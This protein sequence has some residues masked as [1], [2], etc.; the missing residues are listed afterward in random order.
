MSRGKL[1]VVASLVLSLIIFPVLGAHA[2]DRPEGELVVVV[3]G[4]WMQNLDPQRGSNG[5]AFYQD[6][7]YDPLVGVNSNGEL[8]PTT[9]VA[10]KWEYSPDPVQNLVKP[11]RDSSEFHSLP[12]WNN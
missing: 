12:V 2:A 4:L 1:M 3:S 10:K 8:D 9:G 7:M 6:V 11:V 5:S